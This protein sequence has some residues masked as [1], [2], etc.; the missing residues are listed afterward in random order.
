[1]D[2]DLKMG[3]LPDAAAVTTKGGGTSDEE[4]SDFNQSKSRKGKEKDMKSEQVGI[5]NEIMWSPEDLEKFKQEVIEQT[6]YFAERLWQIRV[7]QFPS[8]IS[9]CKSDPQ[10]EAAIQKGK[11]FYAS[12]MPKFTWYKNFKKAVH[13]DKVIGD[14][15]TKY[16]WAPTDE[17]GPKLKTQLVFQRGQQLSWTIPADATLPHMPVHE[18]SYHRHWNW[19]AKKKCADQMKAHDS[20]A[21]STTRGFGV[22][23]WLILPTRYTMWDKGGKHQC[24]RRSMREMILEDGIWTECL[25]KT[26]ALFIFK[27]LSKGAR[28]YAAAQATGDSISELFSLMLAEKSGKVDV[29]RCEI[30]PKK[31][32][33]MHKIVNTINVQ[34]IGVKSKQGLYVVFIF[35]FTDLTAVCKSHFWFCETDVT[36]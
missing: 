24:Y 36:V 34:A 12:Y 35:C 28:Y 3:E 11:N 19:A 26:P 32:W 7:V 14:S 6:S 33:P 18:T 29:I 9:E 23:P 30:D 31:P 16:Y 4:D 20:K 17:H 27:L 22:L 5:M 21:L 8:F 10:A 1:M 13:V 15:V 25:Y 2:Q